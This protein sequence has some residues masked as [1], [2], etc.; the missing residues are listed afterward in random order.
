MLGKNLFSEASFQIGAYV[1]WRELYD[2]CVHE[3]NAERLETLASETESAIVLRF[4]DLSHESEQSDEVQALRQA[5]KVL[6][7][8]R[9][10]KLGWPD[11]FKIDALN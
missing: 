2:S 10:K 11:P 6:L 1:S 7:E 4:R 5:A 9:I 3:T 8:I